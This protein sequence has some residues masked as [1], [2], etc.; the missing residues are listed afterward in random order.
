MS[1]DL[2]LAKQHLRVTHDFEDTVITQY[3]NAAVAWVENYTGKLLTRREVTQE[4]TEF[5]SYLT[6]FY[7]PSPASLTIDYT[8]SEG[9]ATTIADGLVVKGRVY[10]ADSWPT[11]ADN[12]P[13]TLTYTAGYDNVPAD[14]DSAVLVHVRAQYDEWRSGQKDEV[15]IVAI[16]AL[17]RPYR[18]LRV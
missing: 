14:L 18:D 2:A 4:E 9:A 3:L 7:G 10:P 5:G 11:F 1:V 15:A 6:L 8:D 12:T 17:C 16:E 13:V